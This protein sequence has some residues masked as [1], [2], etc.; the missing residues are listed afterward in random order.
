MVFYADVYF[1]INFTVDLLALYFATRLTRVKSSV[2][3][4]VGLAFVGGAFALAEVLL[5]GGLAFM[6]LLGG[7]LMLIIATFIARKVHI[8]RRLRCALTFFV[9]EAL[10]GGVVGYGY[11]LFDRYLYH[12]ISDGESDV[13]NRRLL[14]LALMI[15]FT[16]LV[17]KLVL[18][19]F[20]QLRSQKNIRTEIELMGKVIT[21]DALVDSGNLLKEPSTLRPVMLLKEE[22]MKSIAPDM[23]LTVGDFLKAD[24]RYSKRLCII[25]A[26]GTGGG[27]ILVGVRPDKVSVFDG[28]EKFSV[29]AVVAVDTEGGTY[30]GFFA[31]MPAAALD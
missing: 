10:I 22:K 5:G 9:L 6:L 15:L 21:V 12:G 19:L 24:P 13:P 23:P 14:I 8:S 11:G 2:F 20:S 31:L 3:R 30:G 4:I 7:A 27:R 26:R 29:D 1:L 28:A 16:V 25:P 18:S 17:L